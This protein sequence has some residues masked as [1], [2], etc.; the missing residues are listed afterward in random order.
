MQT[1]NSQRRVL[2]CG[3]AAAL[4]AWAGPLRATE[5]YPNK[6]VRLVV[7]NPPGGLTDTVSR[8]LAP[9]LQEA[10]GQPIVIDNKPGGNGGVAAATL[11]Q[12]P[13]D[14]YS[15]LVADGSVVSVNPLVSRNLAYDPK[16]L[17]PVSLV[18]RA[19]LFLAVSAR[20]PA[21]TLDELV[22]LVRS[23]PGQLNYGSSGNG[24]THHLT[25]EA[26]KAE[27]GLAITHIPY[28]GSAASVPALL[29]GEVDMVFSA[30]PSLAGFAKSG[31]VRLL[32]TNAAQRSTLAPDVP[33]I[34][35]K[36]PGFDYAPQVVL[37]AAP[38]TPAEAVQRLGREIGKIAQR[39]D[40]VEAL[41]AAGVELVG[42][43]AAQLATTLAAEVER[44]AR[45][46]VHANLKAE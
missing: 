42:G 40:V 30:Y 18:A 46:A 45:T 23:R 14:G 34:A 33:A 41:T 26:L 10:L 44:M 7:A 16:T 2:V 35:E 25:M 38:G 15:F 22:A 24:S 36:K 20:T 21:Q 31:Q 39:K 3:G 9:R 43:S 17:V 28:R 11:T 29:G 12:S 6:P 27:Y 8:A 13:P 1:I 5:G 4:A 32:A 19:P 37:M